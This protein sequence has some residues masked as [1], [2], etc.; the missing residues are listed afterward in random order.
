MDPKAGFIIVRDDN[1]SNTRRRS[2]DLLYQPLLHPIAYALTNLLWQLGEISKNPLFK[3]PISDLLAYLNVDIN[4]FERALRR[5]EG[6]GLMRTFYKKD[7]VHPF[8]IFH[9]IQPVSAREFFRSDLLSIGLLEIV[10]GHRFLTLSRDLIAKPYQFNN[11]HDLTRNFLEVYNVGHQDI[12]DLPTLIKQIR[13]GMTAKMASSLKEDQSYINESHDFNFELLLD[14]MKQSYSDVDAV[15]RHRQLIL[16]EHTLYGLDEPAMANCIKQATSITSNK[17]DFNKFKWLISKSFQGNPGIPSKT[18]FKVQ[19]GQSI[20]QNPKVSREKAGLIKAADYYSPV[21]FLYHLKKQ[22]NSHAIV[23]HQ[24][25]NILRQLID[26]HAFRDNQGVINILS[27]YMIVEKH[28]PALQSTYMQYIMAAWGQA[29]VNT[30]AEALNEIEKFNRGVTERK[31]KRIKKMQGN[32][33][34]RYSYNR[35]KPVIK[36]KLPKWARSD[37]H[38]KLHPTNPKVQRK[39][40]QQLAKLNHQPNHGK[41]GRK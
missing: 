1:L 19:P 10:G 3:R 7:S 33:A 30:P 41:G 23:T 16:T 14:L 2:L 37:Y 32:H 28:R 11:V 20:K 39:I 15:K 12:T 35:R 25:E 13:S 5:V 40:K 31:N 24:E 9:L 36:Q 17:I 4:V 21:Q 38:V 8:Y 29:G 26:N 6:A 22:I 34:R 18:K 27:Y